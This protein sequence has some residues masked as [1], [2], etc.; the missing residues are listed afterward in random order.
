MSLFKTKVGLVVAIMLLVIVSGGVFVKY[1]QNEKVLGESDVIESEI[2][3][4]V[5]PH[6]ELADELIMSAI[7]SS[8]KDL[9][10]DKV[11]IIGPNHYFPNSHFI[12][13]T[14]KLGDISIDDEYVQGLSSTYDFVSI[15]S[16]MLENEHSVGIPINYLKEAY[17]KAEFVPLIVS[18][19][20]N[21]EIMEE[22]SKSLSGEFSENVLFVLAVD[23]AHNVGFVEAMENN[24]ESI[25]SISNFDYESILRYDDRHMDSPL[26]TI[27]FLKIMER[28][29]ANNW[30]I[31][32]S[33]HGSVILGIPDLQGTSYVT[34]V[35]TK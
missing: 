29:G 7:E 2:V 12:T 35:Y 24:D 11:V 33:S 9:G 17:P 8:R 23:F 18:H 19:H 16:Q 25:K 21:K 10:Y 20:Y 28:L 3:G 1:K 6:H 14:E 34:G 30:K 26:S 22:L 15:D 27:L 13:T 32:D 31:L 4:L 5:I